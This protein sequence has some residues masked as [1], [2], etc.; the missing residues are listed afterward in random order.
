MLTD[1]VCPSSSNTDHA[2]D[3]PGRPGRGTRGTGTALGV[4]LGIGQHMRVAK[5]WKH[6]WPVKG[7][8]HVP[9]QV[10]ALLPG[11][12]VALTGSGGRYLRE[13]PVLPDEYTPLRWEACRQEARIPTGYTPAK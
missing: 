6:G 7:A 4:L 12:G 3:P 1:A 13:E 10:Q 2:Y 8:L 5:S 11:P 9:P